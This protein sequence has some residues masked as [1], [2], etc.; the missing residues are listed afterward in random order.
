MT[1]PGR[2]LHSVDTPRA[3][4][5]TDTPAIQYL[6]HHNCAAVAEFLGQEPCC[7]GEGIVS[8]V[9]WE[10]PDGRWAN[11]GDWLIR[12][13]TGVEIVPDGQEVPMV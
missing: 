11:P 6:P 9:E 10:L 13:P 4:T 12:R 1:G 2:G 8:M 3:S 7:E 5:A